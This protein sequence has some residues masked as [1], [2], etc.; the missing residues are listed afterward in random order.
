MALMS[1]PVEKSLVF[2][3]FL[4]FFVLHGRINKKKIV[5]TEDREPGSVMP[6]KKR[7]MR[8]SIANSDFFVGNYV[9]MYKWI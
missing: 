4:P 7:R 8:I 5:K 6:S 2:V 9:N 3:H 1:T